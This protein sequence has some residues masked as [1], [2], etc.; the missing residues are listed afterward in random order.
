[1][2]PNHHP[3]T[4]ALPPGDYQATWKE[5]T[6]RYGRGVRRRKILQ[7]LDH[8]LDSLYEEMEVIDVYLDGS[9]TSDKER[10][11]DVDVIINVRGTIPDRWT[12]RNKHQDRKK[13]WMV[14]LWFWPSL[15]AHGGGT[16]TDIKSFMATDGQGRPTGFIHL[17]DDELDEGE[18]NDQE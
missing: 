7:N 9:F 12:D 1:M 8:I 14:D 3:T 5:V 17:F 13:K 15:G 16:L 2:I 11:S 18:Q 6:Q 4:G 10:P